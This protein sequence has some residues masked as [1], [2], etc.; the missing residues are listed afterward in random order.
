MLLAARGKEGSQFYESLFGL[1]RARSGPPTPGQI[2]RAA[3]VQERV[4][5]ILNR[6]EPRHAEFLILR[7]H[8]FSYEELASILD[9]GSTSSAA[10]FVKSS[11][12]SYAVQ[13]RLNLVSLSVASAP[14]F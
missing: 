3:E 6:L 14:Q 1:I 8:G 7:S 9:V 11:A 13:P 10:K 5:L 4:R 2:H 12:N